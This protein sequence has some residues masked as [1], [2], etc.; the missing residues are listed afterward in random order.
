MQMETALVIKERMKLGQIA[1][2]AILQGLQRLT[3]NTTFMRIMQIKSYSA[4]FRNMMFGVIQAK[5][6]QVLEHNI[7]ILGQ[8]ESYEGTQ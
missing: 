5:T 1:T 6:G 8:S 2:C 3:Q 4:A 7:I